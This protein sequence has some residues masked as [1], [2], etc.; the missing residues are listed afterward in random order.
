MGISV[1][2]SD[3]YPAW[4]AGQYLDVTGL[5][6]GIYHVVNRVNADGSLRESSY[7]DDAAAAKIELTWP[8]GPAAPPSLT[9]L[10]TCIALTCP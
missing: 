10:A 1:G 9:V 7:A 5:P 3:V 6:A 2:W 8:G 4:A